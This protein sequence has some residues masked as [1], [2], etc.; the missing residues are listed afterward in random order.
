MPCEKRP[1]AGP[2]CSRTSSDG[3]DDFAEVDESESARHEAL[4]QDLGATEAATAQY[5]AQFIEEANP[6]NVEDDE[7]DRQETIP[8]SMADIYR[9]SNRNR[10]KNT[11]VGFFV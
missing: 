5:A 6:T 2:H 1:D 10:R 4:L 7:T 8:R 3:S 11:D 9:I